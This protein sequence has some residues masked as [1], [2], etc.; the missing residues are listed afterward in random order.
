MAGCD[1]TFDQR[2]EMLWS[3]H[4]SSHALPIL[5][6]KACGPWPFVGVDDADIGHFRIQNQWPL[7][8]EDLDFSFDLV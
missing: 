5:T 2:Y 8:Q 1:E 7:H 3:F 4:W 6:E